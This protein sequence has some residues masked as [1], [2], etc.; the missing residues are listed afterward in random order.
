MEDIALGFGAG[1]I[2]VLILMEI[3]V[4]AKR[5]NFVG[6]KRVE[7]TSTNRYF[8]TAFKGEDFDHFVNEHFGGPGNYAKLVKKLELQC[9]ADPHTHMKLVSALA[10]GAMANHCM[11]C[12]LDKKKLA[13]RA[14]NQ[15][16]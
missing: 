13:K 11:D 7:K 6:S 1:I 14:K 4:A 2:T 15:R 9:E 12:T 10:D 16:K 5:L 8:M 3:A